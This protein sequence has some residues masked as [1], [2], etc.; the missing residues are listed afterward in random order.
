MVFFCISKIGQIPD[1]VAYNF[2][3]K[4]KVMLS[5]MGFCRQLKFVLP[6]LPTLFF[7]MLNFDLSLKH[8]IFV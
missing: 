7:L 3:Q 1:R 4:C 6:T 2:Y 5:K 8:D